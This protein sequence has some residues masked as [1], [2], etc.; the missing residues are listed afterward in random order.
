MQVF[1]NLGLLIIKKFWKAGLNGS[2]LLRKVLDAKNKNEKSIC[3]AGAIG[4]YPNSLDE[5]Y[6][7][8]SPFHNK[9]FYKK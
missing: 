3:C 7:E 9:I 1:L 2:R 6:L 8:D 5:V 4:I